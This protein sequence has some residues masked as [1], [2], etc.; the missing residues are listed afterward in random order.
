[1]DKAEI[2]LRTR[3]LNARL[4]EIQQ[5][6]QALTTKLSETIDEAERF[7][8]DVAEEYPDVAVAMMPITAALKTQKRV[9]EGLF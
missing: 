2:E 3:K 7:F 9:V 4:A 5:D 6:R 8:V 1:M